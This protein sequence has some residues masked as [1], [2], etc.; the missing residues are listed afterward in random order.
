MLVVV[1]VVVKQLP[2]VWTGGPTCMLN[3]SNCTPMHANA[4]GGNAS[5]YYRRD[6]AYCSLTLDT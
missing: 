6:Q 4:C 2:I 1:S 5:A 3:Q